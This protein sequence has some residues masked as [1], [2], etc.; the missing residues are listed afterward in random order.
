MRFP[1]VSL[2]SAIALTALAETTPDPSG[3]NSSQAIVSDGIEGDDAAK[4]LQSIQANSTDS[5]QAACASLLGEF[6]AAKVAGSEDPDYKA[7]IDGFWSQQQREPVPRCIFRPETAQEVANVVRVSQANKC[8]FAFRSG[9]HAQFAGASN[10]DGGITVLFERMAGITLSEDKKIASIGPGALWMDIYTNLAEHNLAVVGGRVADVGIGGLMTGGGISY[11]SNQYGWAC[12][13]VASY[14][15][16]LADGRI[17]TATPDSEYSDLFWALRGGGNNVGIVTQFNLETFAHGPLMYGGNR[18]FINESFSAAIDAFVD[19]AKNVE[20]DPKATQFLSFALDTRN[21]MRLAV[22][23]LQYADPKADAPIFDTWNKVPAIVDNTKIDSL[24]NLSLAL[25][26]PS[27]SGMRQSYWT[28]SVKLKDR[29]IIDRLVDITFD[30]FDKLAH[31][32]G[33]GPAQTFQV[34]TEPQLKNMEKNGGNA[35]GLS[36]SDG[37]FLLLLQSFAWVNS[38]DD[39]LVLKTAADMV[40]QIKKVSKDLGVD[41]DYLYMNY[42]SQFQDVITSYGESAK[43][44]KD[45]A[46]K[47]DPE[48]VFQ[49]L[50][51]GYHKL[52]GPKSQDLPVWDRIKS[53]F[54]EK[55]S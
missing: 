11:F 33:I 40:A 27:P 43:K 25:A 2:F 38:E 23:D 36:V 1:A 51:P 6:G 52:N 8:R 4:L 42:A 41:H 19:L 28:A 32:P 39:E 34:V 26:A 47:Y 5:C 29:E 9:G 15:V 18:V 35:L 45:I 17:V 16:V 14:E 10:A 44:L 54:N 24:V 55:F 48:G 20:K 12:D 22:A 49:T 7:A 31:V 50:Q 37:P 3:S 53:F 30:V 13:N 46:R 21:N